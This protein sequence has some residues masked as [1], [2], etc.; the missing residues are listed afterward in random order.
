MFFAGIAVIDL[1]KE[2]RAAPGYFKILE[3][4]EKF[5]KEQNVDLSSKQ[6]FEEKS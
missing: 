3:F 4:F 1:A 2:T 6:S 5:Y